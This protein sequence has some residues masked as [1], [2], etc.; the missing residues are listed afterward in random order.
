MMIQTS[1]QCGHS[2][3]K[4][5]YFNTTQKPKSNQCKGITLNLDDQIKQECQNLNQDTASCF[6]QC[7]K[8]FR[9]ECIPPGPTI[10]CK[11]YTM[12]LSK[13]LEITKDGHWSYWRIIGFCTRTRKQVPVLNHVPYSMELA[14]CN[15]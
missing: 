4:L 1:E 14:P 11:N 8:N 9:A 6:L 13:F 12:L 7:E 5:G 2:P 3:T 10:N 15:L